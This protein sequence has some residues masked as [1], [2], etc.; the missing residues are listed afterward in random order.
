MYKTLLLNCKYAIYKWIFSDI[1][2]DDIGK[3]STTS[4]RR[5]IQNGVYFVP[6]T[7]WFSRIKLFIGCRVGEVGGFIA[8]NGIGYRIF[9]STLS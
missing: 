5:T 6:L 7:L 1:S 8:F 2:G 4:I 3:H 9:P